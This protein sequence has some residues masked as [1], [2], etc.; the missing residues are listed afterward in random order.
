[1]LIGAALLFTGPKVLANSSATDAELRADGVEVIAT[2]TNNPRRFMPLRG[3]EYVCGEIVLTYSIDGAEHAGRALDSLCERALKHG[4]TV[5]IY[6]D[7]NNP[8]AFIGVDG[9][10]TQTRL[11]DREARL[12]VFVGVPM[13][14]VGIWLLIGPIRTRG[15]LRRAPWV[16]TT[17]RVLK[18]EDAEWKRS[19]VSTEVEPSAVFRV[20]AT[21]LIAFPF[22][23]PVAEGASTTILLATDRR[24]RRC[25]SKSESSRA[26]RASKARRA[27]SQ[28]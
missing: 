20:K 15:V 8:D 28:L 9:S 26:S 27:V 2:V 11:R 21:V 16:P 24:G 25:V 7:P 12:G 5:K 4:E 17:V 23:D 14:V 19:T 10:I 6:V 3:T 13:L 1:M 18:N 22:G